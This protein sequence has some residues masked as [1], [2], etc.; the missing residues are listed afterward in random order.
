ME[1]NATKGNAMSDEMTSEEIREAAREA[2][3]AWLDVTTD[4]LFAAAKANGWD[5]RLSSAANENRSYYYEASRYTS[6]DEYCQDAED[7]KIRISD[8]ACRYGGVDYSLSYAGGDHRIEQVLSRL[9][10]PRPVIA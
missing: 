8:H 2:F 5:L 4:Q 3:G 1:M 7:V 10:T 6:D 9:A